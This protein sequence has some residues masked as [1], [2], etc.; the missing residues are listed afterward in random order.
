[1]KTILRS[2]D[3]SCP[4]CVAKIEKALQNVEGVTAAKVH[5]NT[6]RI[7]V[8]HDPETVPAAKLQ[9]TVREIGYEAAVAAF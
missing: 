9:Q 7:E 4:S 3:L 1:M 2:Q 8:E 5:F 6:G